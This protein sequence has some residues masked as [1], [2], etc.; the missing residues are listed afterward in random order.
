MVKNSLPLGVC[1]ILFLSLTSCFSLPSSFGPG[2]SE[3]CYIHVFNQT[4]EDID[5]Y[6]ATGGEIGKSCTST[7]MVLRGSQV[8]AVGK[9]SGI[10]YGTIMITDSMQDWRLY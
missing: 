2:N 6:G 5:L 7:I 1:I 4:N 3:Y 8:S 10:N 9:K